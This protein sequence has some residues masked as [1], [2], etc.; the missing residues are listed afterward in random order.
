MRRV[1]TRDEVIE[2]HQALSLLQANNEGTAQ[3]FIIR[4][5]HIFAKN[6]GERLRGMK[7]CAFTPQAVRAIV[8]LFSRESVSLP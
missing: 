3:P 5:E 8:K 7:N 6:A 4:E 2:I 1:A